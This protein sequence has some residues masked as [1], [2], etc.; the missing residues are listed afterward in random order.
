MEGV[1]VLEPMQ[2]REESFA[3]SRPA[4]PKDPQQQVYRH[5]CYE[6]YA[7]CNSQ[8][9]LRV[10]RFLCPRCGRTLSVLPKSRLPYIAL[11]TAIVQAD[12]DAWASGTDPPAAS[13][14]ERGCL[15]RAF[16]RFAGR[17]APLC[18]LLGQMIRPIKPSVGECWKA[19][20]ELDNLEGIVL[21]LGKKFNTSLLADYR[22]LRSTL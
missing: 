18:A 10:E 2:L 4:C 22:C 5:G 13:E 6:R 9:R 12:F 21:L 14:K 3:G 1:G 17:V 8:R 7:D 19:L 20:R 15:R 16:D 11:S